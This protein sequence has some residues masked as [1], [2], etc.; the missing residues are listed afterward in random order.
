[1]VERWNGGMVEWWNG[2]MYT[3]DPVPSL[4]IICACV[5]AT[6]RARVVSP[7]CTG[8]YHVQGPMHTYN[9]YTPSLILGYSTL[10]VTGTVNY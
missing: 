2:G 5:L 8:G 6:I 3:N 4:F 10:I 7:V 9:I 1:M